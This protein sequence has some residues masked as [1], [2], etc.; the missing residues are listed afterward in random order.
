M[1]T[2]WYMWHLWLYKYYTPG[3]PFDWH[4]NLRPAASVSFLLRPQPCEFLCRHPF[5]GTPGKPQHSR[6]WKGRAQCG[7]VEN[8]AECAA[9]RTDTWGRRGR[10]SCPKLPVVEPSGAACPGRLSVTPLKPVRCTSK[11]PTGS[12]SILLHRFHFICCY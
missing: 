2:W 4:R 8:S 12:I 9:S 7:R 10:A 1:H 11:A 5:P 3:S 6:C